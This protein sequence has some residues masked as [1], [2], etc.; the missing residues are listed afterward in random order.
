MANRP[1]SDRQMSRLYETAGIDATAHGTARSSF[2]DWCA[3]G[4]V[5]RQ[6]AE[7][8]LAHSVGGVEG[9]Y[10]RSDLLKRRVVLMQR[11]ADFV[12]GREAD[13]VQNI[14]GSAFVA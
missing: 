5:D 14:D 1:F 9:A 8:A 10:L 2:R 7:A 3:E 11:W 13:A 12:T 6:V 4:G